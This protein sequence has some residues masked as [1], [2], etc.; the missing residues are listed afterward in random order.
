M[1]ESS[2]VLDITRLWAGSRNARNHGNAAQGDDDDNGGLS[3]P[4]P[5]IQWVV[6]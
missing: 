3:P 1:S 5:S 6:V 2:K 4:Q